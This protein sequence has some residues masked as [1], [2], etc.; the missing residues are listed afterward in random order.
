MN[1][2]SSQFIGNIPDNYDRC[3]GPYIF[4]DYANDLARRAAG[5]AP[6]DVLELAS[7][8]GILTRKLR[9]TLPQETQ[10][11]ASDLS[12][13][14]LSIAAE[15]FSKNET[16][17]FSEANAMA[18][19]FDNS[20]FDLIVCQFGVMFFPDKPASFREARRVL[21]SGGQYIFNIWGSISQNPF[22]E[23]ANNVAARFFPEDP[24]GFYKVPFGYSDPDIVMA[25]MAAGGL[26][27]ITSETVSFDKTVDDWTRFAH[28]LVYGNP[29][30]D[31]INNRG[32]VEPEDVELSILSSLRDRFGPEP[33][34]MPLLAT[35]YTG[36]AD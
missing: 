20:T 17:E 11:T 10:L 5:T 12:S 6:T 23:C 4:E 2:Q 35:V 16:V 22:S 7:G 1:D 9:D 27:N 13:P 28:G 18:L 31:E 25:D 19:P 15:K 26:L 30:L 24:P 33:T 34:T 8:T 29:L 14:M 36:T 21:S 32:G 3:L